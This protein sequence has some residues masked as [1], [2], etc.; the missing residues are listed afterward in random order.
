MD[1]L[2]QQALAAALGMSADQLA[3]TLTTQL[4]L[5][6]QS[7]ADLDRD[8]AKV[9]E[10]E[11][12]LSLQE[13]QKITMERMGDV[14]QRF[15]SLLI[16]AAAAAMAIGIGLTL[17]AGTGVILAGAATAGVLAAGFHQVVNDGISP[18]EKGPFTITDSFGATAITA[19]GD[20]LAVSPN[21][22]VQTGGNGG[23]SDMR[24]TNMLLKQI[25]SKEG[26]VKMDSTQ[27]GTAFAVGSR[28]IQ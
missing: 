25:L 21:I 12:T 22:D 5:S 27:V 28:Q 13:Q 19:K 20:G 15:G 23:D 26:T 18:P 1:V 2:Q 24:E 10:Q 9:M 16:I 3:D 14:A 11:K 6:S 17:G 8:A 4:A 7:Q